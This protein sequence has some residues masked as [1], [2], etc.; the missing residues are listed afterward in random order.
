MKRYILSI[1]LVF[2]TIVTFAETKIAPDNRNIIVEGAMHLSC[3][4]GK[5][6]IDRFSK[7]LWSRE[8]L[9]NFVQKKRLPSLV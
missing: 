1:L 2:C 7:D 3:A 9:N 8:D 5:M 6:T 4:D